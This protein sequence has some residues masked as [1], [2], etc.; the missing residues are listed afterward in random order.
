MKSRVLVVMALVLG[1]ALGGTMVSPAAADID[2]F[3]RPVSGKTALSPPGGGSD[4]GSDGPPVDTEGDPEN[5]LGG[6]NRPAEDT[7]DDDPRVFAD[8]FSVL[9]QLLTFGWFR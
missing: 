1:L 4:D 2:D 3:A 5:W 7:S 8:W 6:Q 9:I